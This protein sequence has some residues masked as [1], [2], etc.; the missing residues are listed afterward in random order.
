MFSPIVVGPSLFALS[1]ITLIS[2]IQETLSL[3]DDNGVG[4]HSTSGVSVCMF[5]HPFPYE[6]DGAFARL[7]N[8]FEPLTLATSYVQVVWGLS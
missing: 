3:F 5:H 1:F 7:L 4:N 8:F 6:Y 2:K